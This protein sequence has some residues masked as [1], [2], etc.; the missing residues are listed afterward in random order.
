MEGELKT[1][2]WSYEKE[3]IFEGGAPVSISVGFSNVKPTD[4]I[5]VISGLDILT[6]QVK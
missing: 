4:V 3:F 2:D 5:N 1:K 6:T